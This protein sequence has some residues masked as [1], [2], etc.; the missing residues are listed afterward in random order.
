MEANEIVDFE[1]ILNREGGQDNQDLQDTEAT[2]QNLQNRS[3][4]C[5]TVEQQGKVMEKILKTATH[6][7]KRP[8][9]LNRN[10]LQEEK[11]KSIIIL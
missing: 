6:S 3:K 1:E 2:N 10:L 5:E 9:S 11:P 4:N 7:S 8:S